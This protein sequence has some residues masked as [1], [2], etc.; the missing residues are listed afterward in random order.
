MWVIRPDEFVPDP[1]L[2]RRLI[3]DTWTTTTGSGRGPGPPAPVDRG[4]RAPRE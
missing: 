2:E 4:D 1:A 3:S